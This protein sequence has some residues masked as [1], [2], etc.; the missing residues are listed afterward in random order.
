MK[1]L[2]KNALFCSFFYRVRS[3]SPKLF[4]FFL[5]C[6][7]LQLTL[8]ALKL[9]AT[10]FLLYGMFS[11]KHYVPDTIRQKTVYLNDM[12]LKAVRLPHRE[13]DL[14]LTGIDNYIIMK[15]NNGVDV[16]QTRVEERYL[17]LT[18]RSLYPF[19]SP[20]IFNGGSALTGF[21][22]WF[23]QK[24]SKLTKKKI[25]RVT[26]IENRYT[27]DPQTLSI[28]LVAREQIAFF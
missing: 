13:T 25:G 28:N 7:I 9:E 23:K 15:D 26:I 14:L 12:P 24:C 19:I 3:A 2:I 5:S 11:E 6:I 10:P 20:K 27:V 18:N 17:F 16:V 8:T 1:R 4:Y 21:E 22:I